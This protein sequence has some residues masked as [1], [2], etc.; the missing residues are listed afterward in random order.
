MVNLVQSIFEIGHPHMMDDWWNWWSINGLQ[1]LS[2]VLI[3]L[4]WVYLVLSSVFIPR[5]IHRDAVRRG[6]HNSE[7]WFVFGLILNLFGL[8]IYLINRGNYNLRQF[9][10]S[11]S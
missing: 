11:Q 3:S 5:F 4:G 8:I 10:Q 7:F 9:E 6:I 1:W 2:I